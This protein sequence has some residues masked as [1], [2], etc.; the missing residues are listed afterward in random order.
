MEELKPCP[1]CRG[2]AK[3]VGGD[4]DVR[5]IQDENG[6]YIAADVEVMPSWVECID[7]GATGEVFDQDDND[8]QNAAEAWNR[9]SGHGT[10]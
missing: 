6:A 7:C 10:D 1:F 5:P 3:L 9:R 2:K 4:I 8:Q